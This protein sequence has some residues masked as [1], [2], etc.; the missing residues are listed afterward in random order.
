MSKGKIL[1]ARRPQKTQFYWE[2]LCR[3]LSV[4]FTL[5]LEYFPL[6]KFSNKPSFTKYTKQVFT[7]EI[8]KSH[9]PFYSYYSY[10]NL[11]F[12]QKLIKTMQPQDLNQLNHARFFGSGT[13]SFVGAISLTANALMGWGHHGLKLNLRAQSVPLPFSPRLLIMRIK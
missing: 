9:H 1:V 10:L 7:D 3:T 11:I 4:Y 5:T 8:R 2:D 6:G 12:L 13:G